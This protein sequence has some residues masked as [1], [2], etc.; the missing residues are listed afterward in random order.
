MGSQ[1][2]L[3]ISNNDQE[4]LDELMAS[5]DERAASRVTDYCTRWNHL[6]LS[7]LP[8]VRMMPV[9]RRGVPAANAPNGLP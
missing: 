7:N 2:I 3:R 9:V 8:V 1:Q 5:Q 4:L 6:S